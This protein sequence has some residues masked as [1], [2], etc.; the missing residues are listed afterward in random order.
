[1][2]YQKKTVM[3]GELFY[4]DV[5]EAHLKDLMEWK[6]L[7][8][9]GVYGA[10]PYTWE[11]LKK[12]LETSCEA[13]RPYIC[14]TGALLRKAQKDGKRILF[15]AQLGS[16]RDLDYGI[17][18]MTTSSNTIASFAP[19]GS[20]LP[21]ADIERIIG[22]VKAYSTC[23][24][25]GPFVCEMFGEE[26]ERLREAGSEYG[27]KTGR[28]RRVGPI[29]LVA[30]RY[31]VEVQA[32]TE[33]ALTKL[34]VLSDMDEIPVCARYLLDG[35]ETDEFPFPAALGKC[36]PVMTKVPGWKSDISRIRKW[37]DLPEAA[38][39]YVEMIEQAIGCPVKWVSVGP[40]R[41]SIIMR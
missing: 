25:E 26:A 7:T 3:A 11:D 2:K 15:E 12:W 9:K 17:Y 34:D 38:R 31:G 13:I 21:G 16:L 41:E 10:E 19:V 22:V 23:V 4:P 28:P 39:N 30:T 18:P 37:E 8:L 40:E 5:L 33:I 32:A 14:N 29:D 6:N 24:G 36:K 27:A 35:E 20:G 1:D